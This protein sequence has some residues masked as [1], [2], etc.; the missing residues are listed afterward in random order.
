MGQSSFG[1]G[2]LNSNSSAS[3]LHAFLCCGRW[4]NWHSRE[5]YLTERQDAQVLSVD[6]SSS[7]LPQLAQVGSA[8]NDMFMRG[9]GGKER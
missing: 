1:G 7:P 8:E 9:E 3:F 5:Q 6:S 4:A 2:S